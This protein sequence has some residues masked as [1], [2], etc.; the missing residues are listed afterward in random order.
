MRD[1]GIAF[2]PGSGVGAAVTYFTEQ[3]ATSLMAAE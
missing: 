3:Q 2:E 1:V